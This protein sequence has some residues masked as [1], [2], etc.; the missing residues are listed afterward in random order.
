MSGNVAGG[1]RRRMK[2]HQGRMIAESHVAKS[3]QLV[4]GN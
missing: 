3:H 2:I 1:E 4:L